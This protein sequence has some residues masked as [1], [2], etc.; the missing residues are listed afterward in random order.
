ML[1]LSYRSSIAVVP[2]FKEIQNGI[3]EIRC[4]YQERLQPQLREL[5]EQAVVELEAN[6][7]DRVLFDIA[8]D[9]S[10]RYERVKAELPGAY[11]L[12]GLKSWQMR[13]Q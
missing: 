12:A 2:S 9:G 8:E 5:V 1:E 11:N 13:H 7:G 10:Y 6:S 4:E 3:R